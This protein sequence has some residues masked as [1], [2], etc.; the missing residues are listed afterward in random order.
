MS[1]YVLQ[2]DFPADDNTTAIIHSIIYYSE[3]EER[4]IYSVDSEPNYVMF[5]NKKEVDKKIAEIELQAR[6]ARIAKL[7]AEWK[8]KHWL[9]A[10]VTLKLWAKE[11]LID[12]KDFTEG[13]AYPDSDTHWIVWE[14]CKAKN[15]YGTYLPVTVR[16]LF[17]LEGNSISI[18]ID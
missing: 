5:V 3:T 17:D 7:N 12:V 1:N 8:D 13:F 9:E 6:Q 2:F 16:G 10:R 4:S 11:N 15:V 18:G 14:K